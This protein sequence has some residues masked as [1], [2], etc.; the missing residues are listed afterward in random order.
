MPMSFPVT[1]REIRD[2][3]KALL[4]DEVCQFDVEQTL[5]V[6]QIISEIHS[7]TDNKYE[8][9]TKNKDMPDKMIV[10]RIK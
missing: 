3:I 8:T 10:R 6:R 5:R 7:Y 9:S 2:Q 4:Q 1:K